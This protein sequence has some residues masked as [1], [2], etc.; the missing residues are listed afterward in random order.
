MLAMVSALK[1]NLDLA[2]AIPR[3]GQWNAWFRFVT[4]ALPTDRRMAAAGIFPGNR[5]SR[6]PLACFFCKKGEDDIRHIFGDCKPIKKALSTAAQAAGLALP[7]LGSMMA[8]VTLIRPGP[9]PTTSLYPVFIITFVWAV[10]SD[11]LRFFSALDRP[12]PPRQVVSRLVEYTITHMAPARHKRA[13]PEEVIKLANNPPPDALVGF[14]DGSSI[15]NPGPCGAGALLILPGTAGQALSTMA[16]GAGDNNLGEIAGLLQV[17]VLLDEAYARGLVTGHPPLL[18]FTDSLLV[19]GA[20]DWGWPTRGMPPLIRDLRQAYRDRKGLNPVQLYWVK[21]HSQIA[22]N[23]I[24][25]KAARVGAR[26]CRDGILQTETV[27]SLG[28]DPP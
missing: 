13:T 6:R 18:L 1:D 7:R 4:N 25:D 15:P 11:R 8:L 21:G 17:L 27:W 3:P 2:G 20:L 19:V 16:L 5:G 9:P 26:W 12:L 22:R 28:P 14:S 23:E 24:V 10:W